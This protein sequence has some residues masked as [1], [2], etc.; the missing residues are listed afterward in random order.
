MDS[1]VIQEIANQLGMA[2]D[3]AGAFIQQYLPQYA[4]LQ[5]LYN[6][7][8]IILWIMLIAITVVAARKIFV[9]QQHDMDGEFCTMTIVVST[10]FIVF[11]IY[12]LIC[13]IGNAVGWAMF[14]EA[15]LI[16]TVFD[17]VG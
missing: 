9:H 4:S 13:A 6:V 14:P 11:F 5:T 15:S 8:Y 3:D 17:C 10:I 1:S 12:S 2:V 7:M 16:D